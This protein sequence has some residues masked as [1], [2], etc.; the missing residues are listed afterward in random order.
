MS[1]K[2]AFRAVISHFHRDAATSITDDGDSFSV[3]LNEPAGFTRVDPKPVAIDA[4]GEILALMGTTKDGRRDVVTLH[5]PKTADWTMKRVREWLAG[6]GLDK[7]AGAPAP[8]TRAGFER[9]GIEKGATVEEDDDFWV[10]RDNVLVKAG[11]FNRM[12]RDPPILEAVWRLYEGLP[13]THP[14]PAGIVENMESVGGIVRNVRYDAE[15]ARVLADYAYAK[16]DGI[17]G[18]RVPPTMVKLNKETIRRVRA[19]MHVENSQG[20]L[21]DYVNESG[22]LDGREYDVTMTGLIPNHLATLLDEEAACTW[23]DGCGLARL[24]IERATRARRETK[25]TTTHDDHD[26]GARARGA[27]RTPQEA[28]QG[29]AARA[30]PAGTVNAEDPTMCDKECTG[31]CATAK[32]LKTKLDTAT[33]ELHAARGAL[34]KLQNHKTT[35]GMEAVKTPNGLASVVIE[36]LDRLAAFE[37]AEEKA[38]EKLARETARL[39]R[40]LNPKAGE[41]DALATHYKTWPVQALAEHKSLLE[42]TRKTRGGEHRKDT[43]R[44]GGAEGER[45]ERGSGLTVGVHNGKEWVS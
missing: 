43:L 37:H 34:E 19:G 26:E 22:T 28:A 29:N 32:E 5:F 24:A 10:V 33:S 44:L 16:H 13:I 39:A 15:T 30:A 9:G 12:R 4:D 45:Q 8:R 18:L 1:L 7:R 11:V 40:E 3:T 23:E 2:E 41:E 21:Y 17:T 31:G 20:Y 25:E 6:N 27:R 36:R 35:S 42:A 14:H 38:R